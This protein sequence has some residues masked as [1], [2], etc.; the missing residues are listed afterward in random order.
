MQVK[1]KTFLIFVAIFALATLS[2]GLGGLTG[3]DSSDDQ[4]TSP[5]G[6]AGDQ[7]APPSDSASSPLE[8]ADL[9]ELNSYR[10]RM[11]W[12]A[13]NEDSSE[14]ATMLMTEEWVKGPPTAKHFTMS[15]ADY[16]EEQMKLIEY[17]V[18][19]DQAWMKFG[20]TWTQM[21][22]GDVSGMAEAWTGMMSDVGEWEYLGQETV[23]DIR[24]KHYSSGEK[25]TVSFADPQQG[26]G[27]VNMSI[28]AEAWVADESDL[29]PVVVRE[30]AQIEGGFL[31]F[32][33]PGASGPDT[34]EAAH[35]L[36]ETDVTDI[37]QSI[38]IKPPD[39][40][41][42]MPG[43]P[44]ATETGVAE[45]PSGEPVAPLPENLP[46]PPAETQSKARSVDNM[47]MVYIP[48]GQFLM[49]DDNSAFA[50]ERPAH[51]IFLEGYWMD[52]N[53]VNNAQYR[54][55]VDA[56]A[57]VAP[58][59]WE[60]LDLNGDQQPVLVPWSSAQ[61]YCQWVGGRLPTEAEWEK[62]ARST[63]G[64]LWPWGNTFEDDRANLNGEADGFLFTAPVGSFPSG[65]SPYGLNDM[66]G[67]AAEWV[68]DW[69][70]KDY[71]AQSP[72]QNPTGPAGGQDKVIRG[73]IANGGGGREKVRTV[74]RYSTPPEHERWHF[75]FRCAMTTQP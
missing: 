67:N 64:R 70:A 55:C 34:T 23:N 40:V 59:A 45:P 1:Y 47:M 60:S 42:D 71:Y 13:Q 43:M 50:S 27:T 6:S 65:A 11:V 7:P 75:G 56:G 33:I 49:G 74:A 53:E 16:G 29:P 5:P 21:G 52:Q 51:M 4:A 9:T 3:S 37:N 73:T 66:A 28:Q 12:K 69:Y 20:E 31:P 25:E 8:A 46:P 38:I 39:E 32:A 54:L 72:S 22:A 61:A 44:P 63:D 19:G 35:I 68:A 10:L 15:M 14:G 26:G 17:I 41:S 30:R 36:L 62:G 58:P 18:I 57:C 48:N 24:S 2:C